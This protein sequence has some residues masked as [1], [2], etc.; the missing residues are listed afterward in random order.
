MYLVGVHVPSAAAMPVAFLRLGVYTGLAWGLLR[1]DRAAWAG[2]VLE[3][4]R[5]VAGFVLAI[6]ARKWMMTSGLYP[7]SWAQGLL[8]GALP[9]LVAA[10]AALAAGWS[11]GPVVETW[12]TTGARL[13]AG[14]FTLACLWLRRR[15]AVFQVPD[16]L[17]FKTLVRSGFPPAGVLAA[18]EAIALYTALQTVRPP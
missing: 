11:P 18:A 3:L 6:I 2:V 9:L 8:S 13:L 17:S 15:A 14:L 7:A 12:V 5:S 16:P 10:N 1:R 4:V